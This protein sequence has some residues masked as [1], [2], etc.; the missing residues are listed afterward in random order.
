M[1]NLCSMAHRGDDGEGRK[2]F[3]GGLP[4]AVDDDMIRREFGRFG[5]IEDIYLPRERE[6]G[7]ARGFG[8]V[9]FREGRDADD[10]SRDLHG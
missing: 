1:A 3:V 8:F 6:T 2:V 4:F 10:A 9:T 7:K 5:E